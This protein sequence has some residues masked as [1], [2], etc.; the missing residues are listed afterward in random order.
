MSLLRILPKE[1]R[2]NH[3]LMEAAGKTARVKEMKA[4]LKA[5]HRKRQFRQP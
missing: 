3:P 2:K 4:E 1:T 5:A